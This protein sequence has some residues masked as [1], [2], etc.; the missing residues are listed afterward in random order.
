MLP[1]LKIGLIV[2]AFAAS[3][4]VP[5]ASADLAPAPTS[6][7]FWAAPI[8]TRAPNQ[9][10][11][12]ST[13]EA[14]N[15][16][17]AMARINFDNAVGAS[18]SELGVGLS[19]SRGTLTPATGSSL[20]HKGVRVEA[21]D[22]VGVYLHTRGDPLPAESG[23][24]TTLL[25]DEA[26]LGTDYYAVGRA[27]MPYQ[28][29]GPHQREPTFLTVVATR[30]GTTVQITSTADLVPG[31]GVPTQ[32]V[33]ATSTYTMQAFDVLHLET[34][35]PTEGSAVAPDITGTRIQAD[36]P[37]AA[38]SGSICSAIA[39]TRPINWDPNADGVCAALVEQLAPNGSGGVEFAD[40]IGTS[41]GAGTF[42]DGTL[43][44]PGT[45]AGLARIIALAPGPTNFTLQSFAANASATPPLSTVLAGP[46]QW[47]EVDWGAT[48]LESDQPVLVYG[49]SGT[50]ASMTW[51]MQR[52]KPVSEW[53][54]GAEVPHL[55]G[56]QVEVAVV[57]GKSSNPLNSSP[58][59]CWAFE[60]G[61]G[62]TRYATQTPVDVHVDLISNSG[63]TGLEGAH[64][65]SV[66]PGACSE[67]PAGCG[68]PALLPPVAA[69]TATNGN[70]CASRAIQL[71]ASG[72]IDPDGTIVAYDWLFDGSTSASGKTAQVLIQPGQHIVALTVT[73]N[74]GLSS[75]ASQELLVATA[76]CAPHLAPMP[77]QRL[78]AGATIRFC[79]DATDADGDALTF[80][81]GPLPAGLVWDGRCLVGI[82][83]PG[84]YCIQITVSDGKSSDSGCVRLRIYLPLLNLEPVQD[85]DQDGI[86][87]LQDNCPSVPNHDQVDVD[88]DGVGDACQSRL[89]PGE[90]GAD[91]PAANPNARDRDNDGIEDALD[92]CPGVA[93]FRQEDLD[94]DGLGNACDLDW[95]GDGVA[96]VA[97]DCPA[98][99][100]SAQRD[101]DHDGLGD[102]CNQTNR[103]TGPCQ[104]CVLRSR[105][106][107]GG[108][109]VQGAA[110]F[111]F[112]I[113]A[114]AG[115]FVLGLAWTRR[116]N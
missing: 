6:H 70:D 116:R 32:N 83:A 97:D 95:D 31:L 19:T 99:F 4:W 3:G 76:N 37:V 68:P 111:L 27:D 93:N 87:D 46:G 105:P 90:G 41:W 43:V 44:N 104:A 25:L 45:S 26:H 48:W 21:P 51:G 108:Q 23:Q 63:P 60:P 107:S 28:V 9:Q 53:D 13:I 8:P 94:G 66:P 80:F 35:M 29:A 38:F 103:S 71:D 82:A 92:N 34:T 18:A 11:A 101:A 88:D 58:F 20:T 62:L 65:F 24:E 59:T 14:V 47:T 109:S 42:A 16:G 56:E 55:S 106:L 100:D 17:H 2:L 69:F 98:V 78:P 84:D 102:A 79:P 57:V 75:A 49:L 112:W 36:Q 10:P 12:A 33:G 73:D 114:L 64:V 30:D 22:D 40:C 74:D 77:A 54:F 67:R 61:E 91:V 7:V 115:I 113:V 50:G 5:N 86:A 81:V 72:S 52:M 15:A 96:N 89:Q 1:R 85:T 39:T 110:P